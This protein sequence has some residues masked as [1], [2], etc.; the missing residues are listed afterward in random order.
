ML[1]ILQGVMQGSILGPLLFILYI[2]DIIVIIWAI[3][4]LI[5]IYAD[6]TS[7]L[8]QF[9]DD[10]VENQRRIDLVMEKLTRY[11]A[12]N[13]LMFNFQRTQLLICS[14]K[15]DVNRQYYLEQDGNRIYP[16]ENARL[17]GLQLSQDNRHEHYLVNMQNNLLHSLHQR[18]LAVMKVAKYCKLEQRRQFGYGLIVSKMLLEQ[19]HRSNQRQDCCI[20]VV[21]YDEL[22]WLTTRQHL[23]Y[24]DLVQ[25]RSVKLSGEPGML[26]SPVMMPRIRRQYE[27]YTGVTTRSITRKELIVRGLDNQPRTGSRKNTFISRACDRY[28]IVMESE[29]HVKDLKKHTELFKQVIK[30]KIKQIVK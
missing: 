6:D 1:K 26:S 3:W 23:Y 22:D 29:T 7:L 19:L 4:I 10:P 20:V 2:N 8:L 17:L 21:Y 13:G 11:I 25:L 12:S 5:L 9:T 24:H 14:T 30:N 27:I 15:Q 28:N 18:W 16:V